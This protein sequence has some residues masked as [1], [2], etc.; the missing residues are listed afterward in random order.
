M[1]GSRA[2]ILR[3]RGFFWI[4][5]AFACLGGPAPAEELRTDYVATIR[6][7]PVGSAKVRATIGPERYTVRISAKVGGLAR[8]FSDMETS[9]S[10]SGDV[11]ADGLRPEHYEHA[12]R[13][14][15]DAETATIAFRSGN[16]TDV[17]V[18]P[19]P[20]RPERRVPIGESDLLGVLDLGT[21]FIWQLADEGDPALCD[22]TL[23]LFDGTQR[24]DFVLSF[25][26][27]AEF[28]ARDGS[29]SGPATVCAIRYRPISGHRRDKEE[30][31]FMAANED[32]EV[33]MAPAGG[34]FALPVKIR[35]RT[36][37]GFFALEARKFGLGE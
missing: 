15:D 12:W 19:P 20:R 17:T 13:E 10:A 34:G 37:H 2:K 24:F 9:L 35:L 22:R 33:W 21:A 14:G 4:T 36:E 11:R 26:R 7:F 25:S 28:E 3:I 18:D 29:Y 6:G 30:V 5:L 31:A 1:M 23:R 27:F 16:V 8:I 32:I